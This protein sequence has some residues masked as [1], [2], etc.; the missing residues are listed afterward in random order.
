[1][2]KRRWKSL[3]WMIIGCIMTAFLL[4][5]RYASAAGDIVID[6]YYADWEGIP[7]TKISYGSHNAKEQHKGAIVM[8]DEYLYAYIQVSDLYQS[9]IPVNEYYLSVNGKTTVLYILGK[10]A[11]GTVN[12]DFNTYQLPEG[13]YCSEIGVFHR[14]NAVVSLGD[15]AV[16]ITSGQPNDTLEFR[17]S[18]AVLEELCNFPNRAIVNGSRI[19]FYNPNLGSQR[20]ELVG[21]SSG[22]LVGTVLCAASVG[23][24]LVVKKRK[25]LIG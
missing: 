6:G 16:T 24:V 15:A 14:D 19:E 22:A 2:R 21:T 9:Q 3:G 25:K 23:L 20:V 12:Y 18:L 10:H 1:M 5:G 7:K 8:D 13:T 11:D 17:I 4:P